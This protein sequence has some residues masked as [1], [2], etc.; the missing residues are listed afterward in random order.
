MALLNPMMNPMYRS[1]DF[2][3]RLLCGNGYPDMVHRTQTHLKAPIVKLLAGNFSNGETRVEIQEKCR[4]CD[5]FII[6]PIC[7]SEDGK[8]GINDVLME[9]LIQVAALKGSS[10]GRIC[11]VIPYMG[12]SRQCKKDRQRIA[13]TARLIADLIET[14][15]VDRCVTVDMHS[16]QMQGFFTCPVDNLYA[17]DWLIAHLQ[18]NFL[19][20]F[21]PSAVNGVWGEN[22]I[23]VS[24]DAGGAKMAARV[25]SKLGV[26][27]A[28]VSKARSAVRMSEGK[29]MSQLST[30][31]S[32]PGPLRSVLC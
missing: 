13:I 3:I 29:S 16:A 21:Q 19:H 10:A 20:C 27:C 18:A 30:V 24:P 8:R 11:V 15:G 14:A 4:G 12:Y 32:N 2:Q 1:T 5:A 9:L 31:S 17:E 26:P 22:C 6:Q 28:V 25:A 7:Q 23:V